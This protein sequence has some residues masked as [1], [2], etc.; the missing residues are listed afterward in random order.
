MSQPASSA[1]CFDWLA[2]AALILWVMLGRYDRLME[3]ASC[4][5]L[6]AAALLD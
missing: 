5:V 1:H 3:I 4:A 6:A 2:S